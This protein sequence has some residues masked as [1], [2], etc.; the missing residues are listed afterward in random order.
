MLKKLLF[1]ILFASFLVY[2]KASETSPL[3]NQLINLNKYWTYQ[4]NTILLNK[5]YNKLSEIDLIQTHLLLV[6]EQLKRKPIDH[7]PPAQQKNRLQLLEEL[8][9]YANQKT[10][11]INSFHNVRTPYF[12]D[13]LG[14][15]CAVGQLIIKSGN[16]GLAKF[17]SNSNNFDFIEDMPHQNKLLS[18][19]NQYGFEMDELKWIQ[20]SYGPQCSPGQVLQPICRDG[21]GCFNPDWQLDGLISPVTYYSEYNDGTGWVVDSNNSWV[22]SGARIGQHKIT[23]TDATN[24]S[25]I[26]QYT[27]NNIPP[28]PLNA[29]IQ[30]QSSGSFCNGQVTLSVSNS[31]GTNYYYELFNT[32]MNYYGQS[33]NGIFDSLCTGTYTAR[34]STAFNCYQSMSVTVNNVTGLAQNNFSQYIKVQSPVQQYL[35]VNISLTGRKQLKIYSMLGSLVLERTIDSENRINLD[36]LDDGLYILQIEFKGNV[37]NRKIVKAN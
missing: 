11:P 21:Y 17:I 19:A 22:F 12:I 28:I 13:E 7:L 34:V 31:G 20:P 4:E 1:A 24:A 35:N 8:K 15:A 6:V 29:T 9:V 18:W 36:D 14:T 16:E 26:Y 25:V 5:E 10:F 27:I 23:V 37:Y 33:Q 3:I 2:G 32:Q 30:D